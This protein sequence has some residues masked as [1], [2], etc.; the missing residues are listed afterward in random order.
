MASSRVHRTVDEL[1]CGPLR[2]S[3]AVRAIDVLQRCSCE[4]KAGNALLR[5][6]REHAASKGADFFQPAARDP[7][8]DG[9]PWILA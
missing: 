1:A 2:T 6:E 3:L 9:P 4:T 5:A 7:R 8:R